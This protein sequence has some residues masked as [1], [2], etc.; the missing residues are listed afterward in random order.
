MTVLPPQKPIL[1]VCEA[2]DIPCN[3]GNQQKLDKYFSDLLA[4]QYDEFKTE[5]AGFLVNIQTTIM[6]N[7]N[8]VITT[9][10]SSLET[11]VNTALTQITG[12]SGQVSELGGSLTTLQLDIESDI[13]YL[14]G[15]IDI[16]LSSVNRDI[17]ESLANINTDI[18]GNIKDSITDMTADL[19]AASVNATQEINRN[20]DSVNSNVSEVNRLM[21]IN[22]DDIISSTTNN[23]K[24]NTDII[25]GQS[26][27]YKNDI[28]TLGNTNTGIINENIDLLSNDIITEL[29]VDR[30]FWASVVDTIQ[31]WVVA[32]MDYTVDELKD[33]YIKIAIAQQDAA[34]EIAQ[35]KKV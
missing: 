26:T 24:A 23:M 27:E 3:Q 5:I 15:D 33:R 16:A 32:E 21:T 7:T 6:Q 8:D 11:N 34:L 30:L 9:E 35:A 12:V 20:I 10:L 1:A 25:L 19:S 14:L 2:G 28:I 29:G 4:W 13:S 31:K 17:Q 22:T 18:T